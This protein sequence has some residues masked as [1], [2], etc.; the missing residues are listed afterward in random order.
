MKEK[1]MS[2]IYID[3]LNLG[4][5]LIDTEDFSQCT[6]WKYN[7]RYNELG[8]EAARLE[9]TGK[10][11]PEHSKLLKEMYKNGELF[12]PRGQAKGKRTGQALENIRNGVRMRKKQVSCI[13]CHKPTDGSMFEGAWMCHFNNHH[14]SC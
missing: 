6:L 10:K 13:K 5:I 11:R 14:K 3:P 9:N 4:P 7:P 12:M 1:I 8:C 2:K